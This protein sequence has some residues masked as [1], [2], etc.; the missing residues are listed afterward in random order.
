MQAAVNESS[1]WVPLFLLV[2]VLACV[3]T[4]IVS[5]ILGLL[6]QRRAQR[7]GGF[8]LGAVGLAARIWAWVHL[9]GIVAG[10]VLLGAFV[11]MCVG[12]V[13]NE[14]AKPAPPRATYWDPVPAP[15]RQVNPHR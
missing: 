6:E 7:A 9:I 4:P 13:A 14:R 1:V 15:Y 11:L 5:V 12:L 10:C 2:L 3:A 8:T